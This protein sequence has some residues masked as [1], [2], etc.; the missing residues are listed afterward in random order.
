MKR[1]ALLRISV[2]LSLIGVFLLFLILNIF[3][4]SS[5]ELC[6]SKTGDRIKI[7][8]RIK[9]ITSYEKVSFIEFDEK[10][11]IDGVVFDFLKVEK[12]EYYI[13]GKLVEYKGMRELLIDEIIAL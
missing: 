6:N 5:T 2:I 9:G 1:V 8:T 12:G 10:C 7:K 3:E 4:Y 11:D 13:S